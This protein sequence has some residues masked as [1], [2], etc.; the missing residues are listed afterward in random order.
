MVLREQIQKYRDIFVQTMAKVNCLDE[1]LA[2]QFSAN[3]TAVNGLGD[4]LPEMAP[5]VMKCPQCRQGDMQLKQRQNN[6]GWFIGCGNYPKCKNAIWLPKGGNFT[7]FSYLFD[8]Y[9]YLEFV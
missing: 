2:R 8:F 5:K 7:K 6:A 3:P 9:V 4:L 1:A